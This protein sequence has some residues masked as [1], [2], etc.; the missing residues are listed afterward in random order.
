[1]GVSVSLGAADDYGSIEVGDRLQSKRSTTLYTDNV[2][3]RDR[4]FECASPPK[5]GRRSIRSR[6]PLQGYQATNA[7]QLSLIL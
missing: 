5:S 6:G 1:M 2:L 7:E 4:L 3:P